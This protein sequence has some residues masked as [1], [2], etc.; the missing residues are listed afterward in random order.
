MYAQATQFDKQREV[1]ERSPTSTRLH[2]M[3]IPPRYSLHQIYIVALLLASATSLYL[4]PAI[5]K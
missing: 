2:L 4:L 3:F 1:S 5:R